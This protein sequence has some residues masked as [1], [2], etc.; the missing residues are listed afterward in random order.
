MLER[1]RWEYPAGCRVEMLQMN[2][3][4]ASPVGTMGIVIG[5]DPWLIG[6]TAP[7]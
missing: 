1:L 5:I 7:G 6:I 3:A 2:D 4:T